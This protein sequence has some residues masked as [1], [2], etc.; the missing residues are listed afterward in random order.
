MR[1]AKQM[2]IK[3]LYENLSA[4]STTSKTLLDAIDYKK[5]NS[6]DSVTYDQSN[7]DDCMLFDEI[8]SIFTHIDY[9]YSVLTY[10]QKPILEEGTLYFMGNGN[11][12]L[13][14]LKLT[15]NDVV[16]LYTFDEESGLWYWHPI[17]LHTHSNYNGKKARIRAYKDIPSA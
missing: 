3:E 16:E 2:D 8:R 5:N 6:L 11:H 10:L 4:L 15:V 13:N 1:G 12:Q 17:I 14:Q 7:A 9:I